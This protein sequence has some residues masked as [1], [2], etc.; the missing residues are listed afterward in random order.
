MK[1][2]KFQKLFNKMSMKLK[3]KLANK[4]IFIF[5]SSVSIILITLIYISYIRTTDILTEDFIDNNEG[6]LKIIDQSFN[7][8]MQQINEFSLL[9]RND[10]RFLKIIF[11]DGYN[12]ED[13]E[14]IKSSMI[15]LFYSRKD[16]NKLSLYLPDINKSFDVS[17]NDSSVNVKDVK[18]EKEDWYRKASSSWNFMYYESNLDKKL[19]NINN[20]INE[21]DLFTLYRSIINVSDGQTLC[22]VEI[23]FN[24]NIFK[25]VIGEVNNQDGQVTC[26]FDKENKPFY[27]SD[28]RL[29]NKEDIDNITYKIA[30]SNNIQNYKITLNNKRYLAVFN[31]NAENGW[32]VV[33]LIPVDVIN[34]KVLQTRNISMMIGSFFIIILIILVILVS[35]A[36]TRPLKR[37]SKKMDSV[38]VGNFNTNI[39]SE[40]SDEIANL[41]KKFNSMVL[42]I[43]DL[44]NERYIAQ[45]SEKTAQLKA[46][47]AQVNPHFLYNSLQVISTKAILA[48]QKGISRMV[49]NLANTLRYSI[50]GGDTVNIS[51]EI[52]HVKYYLELQKERFEDRLFVEILT[53]DILEDIKIPKLSIYTIV[54]NS[55]IHG[56]E[57][58]TESIHIFI[59]IYIEEGVLVIKVKD[60]GPGMDEERLKQ[61]LTDMEDNRW[62]EKANESIGLKN[63]NT[64][65]KLLYTQDTSLMIKSNINDGTEITMTLPLECE[66]VSKN[67]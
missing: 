57:T 34:A 11:L 20:T 41:A 39:E 30:H 15:N 36:I 65:L 53:E 37:L 40:G 12:Q 14:Y 35:N 48:E 19:E 59:K 5:S 1:T 13:E 4:L 42:Q 27:V 58:I 2:I 31:I 7:D 23:T 52:E 33:K 18:I 61:V 3:N 10:E 64:R 67:V 66:E 62:L 17:R 63:L 56:L 28:S 6:T 43:N 46:L 49:E 29:S 44:I 32:E 8:F 22:L 51:R 26:I 38:G 60:D 16:I 50:K 21:N 9:L 54:E 24:G 25:K 47:E 55:I 45:I